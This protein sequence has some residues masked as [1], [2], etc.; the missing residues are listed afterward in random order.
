M[1]KIDCNFMKKMV[2]KLNIDWLMRIIF[3]KV[4]FE[5]IILLIWNIND[6]KRI[7]IIDI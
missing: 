5:V 1:N 6:M 3:I 7:S 4:K 2:G